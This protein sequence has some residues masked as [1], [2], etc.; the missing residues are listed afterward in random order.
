MAGVECGNQVG[1]GASTRVFTQRAK[2]TRTRQIQSRGCLVG[3]WRRQGCRETEDGFVLG[4]E[5]LLDV[6]VELPVGSGSLGCVQIASSHDM[7]VRCVKV[8]R[9]CDI[10]ELGQ[11]KELDCEVKYRCRG[12]GWGRY[13]DSGVRDQGDSITNLHCERPRKIVTTSDPRV[14]NGEWHA[15]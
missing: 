8:Q 3:I 14:V 5:R 13:D 6:V 12:G 4:F 10:F 11:G 1:E 15:L 7:T 9:T 2:R